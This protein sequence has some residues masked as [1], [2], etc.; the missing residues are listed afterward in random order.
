MTV[1]V[2][3][4]DMDVGEILSSIAGVGLTDSLR[5]VSC[6][7]LSILAENGL[8]LNFAELGCRWADGKSTEG[9]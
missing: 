8:G 9:V 1:S 6:E 7:L 3:I 5:C 4:L 2:G